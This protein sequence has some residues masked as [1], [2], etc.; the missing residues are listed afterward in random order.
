MTING[1][2][3]PK[4]YLFMLQIANEYGISVKE[5]E[6]AFLREGMKELGFDCE[7]IR[8]GVRKTDKKSHCKDC[9]QL[10]RQIKSPR[11]NANKEIVE[12]GQ[13]IKEPTFLEEKKGHKDEMVYKLQGETPKRSYHYKSETIPSTVGD[14]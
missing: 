6:T 7:H 8:M 5:V 1:R 9:W 12:L 2:H 11:Y 4:I 10:F 13:Y 14:M 3:A